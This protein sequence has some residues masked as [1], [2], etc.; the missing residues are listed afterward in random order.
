M[1]LLS[2]IKQSFLTQLLLFVSSFLIVAFSQA[3]WFEELAPLAAFAGIGLIVLLLLAI[4]D[5]MSRFYCA[6]FWSFLVQ[7]V[8]IYWLANEEVQ[9]KYIYA[10]YF[11]LSLLFSLQM[12]IWSLFVTRCP[13][14]ST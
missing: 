13:P 11:F 3:G 6:W 14:F 10:L 4:T 9:G 7:S 8:G 1:I 12:G 2:S 5:R